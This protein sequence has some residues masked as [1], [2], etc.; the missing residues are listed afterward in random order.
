[1][2][3]SEPERVSSVRRLLAAARRVYERRAKLTA[4]IAESTGLSAEGVEL[5][6]SYLELEASDA[7]LA[8]LVAGVSEANHVHVILSANVFVAA[9]RALALAVA[10]APKVTVRPSARDPWLTRALFD[11][12]GEPAV[13]IVDERDPAALD[14]GSL[15]VY[16]RDSTIAAVR[17]AAR[18]GTAVLGHG[19]GLGVVILTGAADIDGSAARIAVDIV[20]FDQRGCL[21][22]RLVLV[23]GDVARGTRVA[24]SL[25]RELSGWGLRVPRGRLESHERAQARQWTD[26]VSFAGR[27]WEGADHVVGLGPAG[28]TPAL[29]PPGRHVHV[30]D[31]ATLERAATLLAPI[32][33]FV[34]AVGTDD[35]AG[36]R[37]VVPPYARLSQVGR[38]QRPPLDGP[39]DRRLAT[40]TKI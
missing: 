13:E 39:V 35:S 21:S 28:E 24:E 10:A 6:F 23:E 22:P 17:A 8:A 36:V 3:R 29:P 30:A 16:G 2:N 19:A 9:L 37:R 25:H 15:H 5:G 14:A 32:S 27:A 31:V 33:R 26:T 18:A 11:E 40:G 1:V 7:E 4:A 38:M 34:A 12:L 20:A